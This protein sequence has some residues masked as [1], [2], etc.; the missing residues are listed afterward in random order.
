MDATWYSGPRGSATRAHATYSIYIILLLYIYNGSSAF[1]IWEGLLIV[2][3]VGSYKPDDLCYFFPC[4]TNPHESYLMQMT[5]RDEERRI[6]W[7]M[8]RRASIACARGPP[9]MIKT[10]AELN[11]L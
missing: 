4:G 2:L 10:R 5:W 7:A 8:N 6:K 1:P 3:I 9:A 11:G